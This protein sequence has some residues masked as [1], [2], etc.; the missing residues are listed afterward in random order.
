LFNVI[1]GETRLWIPVRHIVELNETPCEPPHV[2]PPL[3]PVIET[4]TRFSDQSVIVE[5]R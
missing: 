4:I 1:R 3:K 2:I 5:A